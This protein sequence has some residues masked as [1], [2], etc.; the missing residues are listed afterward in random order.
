MPAFFIPHSTLESLMP[1]RPPLRPAGIIFAFALNLLLVTL[2][3]FVVSGLSADGRLAGLALVGSVAAGLI[4]AFYVRQRA[5][6]HAAL[7]GLISAPVLAIFILP[8]Q[9]WGF[10]I[11]AGAFCALGGILAE[12]RQRR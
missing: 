5:A 7:G 10:A 6:V 11:L 9:N 1:T 4:T 12:F 3:L 8:N 2:A